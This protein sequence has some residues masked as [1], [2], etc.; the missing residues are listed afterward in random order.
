MLRRL[1]LLSSIALAGLFSSSCGTTPPKKDFAIA[2]QPA[3]ASA[4]TKKSVVTNSKP[5][6]AKPVART[7]AVA[8]TKPAPAPVAPK[9]ETAAATK[10]APA[11]AVPKTEVAAA[12]KPA[13]APAAA[14]PKAD[15]ATT[16]PAPDKETPKA[17]AAPAAKPAPAPA[18]PPKADV[19][20][21]KPAAAPAPAT[22][23]PKADTAASTTPAPAPAKPA[24]PVETK[25][26]V[27][28]TPATPP[29]A[30]KMAAPAAATKP[31]AAAAGQKKV[32]NPAAKA[33][34]PVAGAPKKVIV[35][36]TTT[37]FRHSSIQVA[38]PTLQKLAETSKAFVIA[39]ECL[40][41]E[42]QLPKKPNKPNLKPDADD[43]AKKRYENDLKKYE[44][45]IAKWTPAMEEDLKA[46]QKALDDGIAK[47]LEKLSPAN[48]KAK[49]IDAVIFANT[50]GMLPLPDR[51][52]FIKWIEEGHGFIAMHSGSDTFH[53][54]PGYIEMLQGEFQTHRSQVPADLIAGDT[55]HPANAGIGPTWDIKQE[56]M[57]LIK[58]QDPKKVRSIFFLRH[59]PNFPDQK[60][61]FPSSWVRNAG[62]GRVFYTSL[63]HRE[64]L[65]SDDPALQ[66][67]INP[68]ETARQ[69]QA[70][71]LGGIK[72][73]LGL[74]EGSST[75]NPEVK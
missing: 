20:A 44:A 67:R 33:P 75:P 2:K 39:D 58:S 27:V 30:P 55:K 59:D 45:E 69:Y 50:T 64:D 19:A 32:V 21:T 13:A 7:E 63:G 23:A 28:A 70:H 34:A 71:I 73:V 57:Y 18:S 60:A 6:P 15:L 17:D 40:Q 12:T 43:A 66:G 51:D 26:G 4:V 31:V 36:T 11:P 38:R 54:F 68:V 3:P 25:T 37:G 56:E 62:K 24:A 42:I 35:V 65:W 29:T 1:L 72:W 53:Q 61:L 48:L 5:A 10:P 74:A 49:G 41:P 52:G 9:T 47:A 14:Q 22:P 46:K 8:T 16:K